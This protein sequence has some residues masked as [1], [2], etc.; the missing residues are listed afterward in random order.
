M[1]S[2]KFP[3]NYLIQGDVIEGERWGKARDRLDQGFAV[4]PF[5]GGRYAALT[6]PV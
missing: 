4:Q 2:A 1:P 6:I 5:S 3:P